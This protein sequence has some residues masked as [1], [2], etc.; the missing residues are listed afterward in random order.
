MMRNSGL[1]RGGIGLAASAAGFGIALLI[2]SLRTGAELEA[3]PYTVAL[4]TT[5]LA[6]WVVTELRSKAD[7]ASPSVQLTE[8][9]TITTGVNLILQA[10]FA[11][12]FD[13]EV[14]PLPV[15]LGGGAVASALVVLTGELPPW[16]AARRPALLLLGY[17]PEAAEIAHLT[18]RPVLGAFDDEPSR[19][20]QS[21]PALG[22][23]RGATVDQISKLPARVVVG[24]R[25]WCGKV[26]AK[27]LFQLRLAGVPVE[28]TAHLYERT[29]RRVRYTELDPSDLFFS[30]ALKTGRHIMAIQAVYTDLM[31]LVFLILLSPLLVITGLAVVLSGGSG[32]V[33]ER[34]E[35]LGFQGIPFQLL[36]FRTRD[37]K[38]GAHTNTG[39]LIARLHLVNLP[40]LLNIVRGEMVFFGPRPVRKEF[41]ERLGQLLPYYNHRF[42]VKPGVVGWAQVNAPLRTIP[43][44]P[45]RMEYDFYYIRQGS[46]ALDFEILMRSILGGARQPETGEVKL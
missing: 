24:S 3:P 2:Y 7:D 10:L 38:T 27:L 13:I 45:L 4:L 46:L 16:R 1:L 31:G 43:P 23:L 32:P 33:L 20:P 37:S 11:Y 14:V 25:N 5:M 6:F 36:R 26:P 12:A 22:S 41:A 28:D 29:L 34:I 40:Q 35:C 15:L 18:G 8:Q 30:P 21:L 17:D 39:E 42:S 44:E 19:V 9:F